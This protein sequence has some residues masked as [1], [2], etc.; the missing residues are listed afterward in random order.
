MACVNNFPAD[1][2]RPGFL[3][4]WLSYSEQEKLS[5]T[6]RDR[7]SASAIHRDEKQVAGIA[8]RLSEVI[9]RLLVF[10]VG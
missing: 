3:L 8:C 2:T 6:D 5:D 7:L 10:Y 1:G 9:C 4:G